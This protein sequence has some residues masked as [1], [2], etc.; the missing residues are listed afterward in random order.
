MIGNDYIRDPEHIKKMLKPLDRQLL[1]RVPLTVEFPQRFVEAGI[2][3]ISDTTSVFGLYAVVDHAAK[4]YSVTNIPNLIEM[5]PY[6]QTREKIEEE[7]YIVLHF[8]PGDAVVVSTSILARDTMLYDTVNE[9]IFKAKIPYYVDYEDIPAVLSRTGKFAK[10]D[11]FK[12]PA[13]VELAVSVLARSKD[14][15]GLRVRNFK[16]EEK[17]K[18][19]QID[20]VGLDNVF[21]AMENTVSKLAGNYFEDAVVSALANKSTKSSQ[22]EKILKA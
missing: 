21:Y 4:R 19:N 17:P 2:S 1:A 7:P 8:E 9:F 6:R 5:D 10:V 15:L 16:S 12:D 3:T 13:I 11:L 22:V 14:D 18:P 20:Y